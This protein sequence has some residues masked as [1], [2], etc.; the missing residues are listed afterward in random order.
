MKKLGQLMWLAVVGLSL[1]AWNTPVLR[2]DDPPGKP[3]DPGNQGDHGKPTDPGQPTDDQGAGNDGK[4]DKNPNKPGIG[5]G[6]AVEIPRINIPPPLLDKLPEDVKKLIDEFKALSDK[7][8]ADQKALL[9][10]LRG[11]NS[12]AKEKIKE[13]LKANRQSFLDETKEIRADIRE[14]LKELRDELKNLK[15]AEA[16]SS[17]GGRGRP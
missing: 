10:G 17:E 7:Y 4:P 9:E 5:R 2:A 6:R 13:Q 11:A 8:V 14:R 1:V 15:P 3:D 12:D 16:G